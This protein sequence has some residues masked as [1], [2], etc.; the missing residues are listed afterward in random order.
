MPRSRLTAVPAFA[1]LAATL[2]AAAP[3]GPFTVRVVDQDTGRGV[4]LIE[5]RTTTDDRFVTDSNGVVAFAEPGLMGQDVFFHV[6]GHGYEVPKDGFGFRGVR[7]TPTSGGAATV[8]V[9]RVNVAERLYRITGQGVY[10]DSVLVG[11][12]VP[13]EQPLLN[14]R[15][16]GQDSVQA[17]VYRGKVYWAWGDTNVP[18]YPLGNFG[19]SGATSE[20]PGRPGG[21]DP[22]R[23][24]NLHYFVDDAGTTRPVVPAAAVPGPGP[25]WLSGLTVLPDPAGRERLIAR[26]VRVKNLGETLEHGLVVFNDET[27][28]FDRLVRFDLAAP[29]CLDGHPARAEAGGA[30]YLYCGFGPPFWVRVRADWAA[31]QDPKAYEGFTCLAP[32]GRFDGPRTRLDRGPDGRLVYGWKTN[33]LPL[34][35][36]QQTRLAAAGILKAGEAWAGFRDAETGAAVEPHGGSV[37]WNPYRRRWVSVFVQRRGSSSFLGEVWFAEADTPAGPWAYARKVATHDRYSFYNPAHH[38]FFDADGGRR[39]YF[40]GTYTADF[41]GNPVKT[42]RYEY[43]QVMYRL[44]LADPRLAL[45]APVYRVGAAAGPPGY[46]LRE[47]VDRAK[48]WGR[49]G[50]VAFFAVPP[51]R[52]RA[53]LVPVYAVPG[54]SGVELT[55]TPP[56]GGRADPLFLAAAREGPGTVPLSEYRAADVGRRYETAAPGPG[57]ERVGKPVCHVWEVPPATPLPEGD[58]KPARVD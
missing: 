9:K 41:S 28:S 43:N 42:P 27:R 24:V 2:S 21:L 38:P 34:T 52:R 23:G 7:L 11:D 57:W 25:K 5:L 37:A 4:P 49:V 58:V 3:P 14:G 40:E 50:G 12:P 10:R 30:A 54:R 36:A 35:A 16:A 13:V 56:A 26:Y 18:A 19:S 51:D 1:A 6:S 32:G 48:A 31:V 46:Q 53:D 15:V 39:I 8:K 20:L 44:D 33:A 17:A 29:L 47:G 55:T 22:D 45:P